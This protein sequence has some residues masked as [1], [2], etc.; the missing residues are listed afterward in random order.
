[1]NYQKFYLQCVALVAQFLVVL[2]LFVLLDMAKVVESMRS[3]LELVERRAD[4]CDTDV[5]R[6]VHW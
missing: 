3:L 1:M 5:C 4:A 2:S 6:K